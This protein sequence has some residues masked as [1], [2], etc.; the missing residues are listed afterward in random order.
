MLTTLTLTSRLCYVSVVSIAFFVIFAVSDT[1]PLAVCINC[2]FCTFI[3]DKNGKAYEDRL[4]CLRLWS[5]CGKEK[6]Q[7]ECY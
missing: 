5:D 1:S 6:E 3:S 7:A 4:K 2:S